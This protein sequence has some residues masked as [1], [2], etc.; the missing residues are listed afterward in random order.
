[1]SRFRPARLSVLFPLVLVTACGFQNLVMPHQG[2]VEIVV[3]WPNKTKA[4]RYGLLTIPEG[5]TRIEVTIL[6]EG[7]PG[8]APLHATLLPNPQDNSLNFLE[9]PVGIKSVEALAFDD[10]GREVAY[11]QV[12]VPVLPNQLNEATVEMVPETQPGSQPSPSP[13]VS[14]QPTSTPGIPSPTPPPAPTIITVAGGVEAAVVDDKDPTLARFHYPRAIAMDRGSRLLYVADNDNHLIRTYDL[15]THAVTTVAH[16]GGQSADPGTTT[17]GAANGLAVGPEGAVYFADA[18]NNQI[19]KLN[20]DGT[21]SVVAGSGKAGA[22]DGPGNIA[23]FNGPV[24]LAFGVD[25]YLYVADQL[26]GKI[27]RINLRDPDLT[28]TTFA[29]TGGNGFHGDNG[30]ALQATLDLP[31]AVAI[32]P[33]GTVLYEAE[34]GNRR[35]RKIQLGTGIIQTVAGNGAISTIGEGGPATTASL[36]L[37][38]SLAFD[39]LGNLYIADGWGAHVGSSSLLGVASRVLRVGNDG[40]LVRVA[41]SLKTDAAYGGDGGDP[42]LAQM[43]NPSGIAF[44]ASGDLFIADT[45]NNRLRAVMQVPLPASPTPVPTPTATGTPAP[46]PTPS[47]APSA[48]AVGSASGTAP[49]ALKGN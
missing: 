37:P 41:G 25:G 49:A 35:V 34:A 33:S 43:S 4:G 9:V 47:A 36:S 23:S 11:G 19:R 45:Y 3:N 38:M 17:L 1:M 29:G 39:N 46:S 24:S 27:R 28:V 22:D 32:A 18:E 31:T 7:I 16:L 2:K 48:Q 40:L 42:T 20:P 26:N 30:Q 6:G 12:T 14:T 13:T 5:T 8:D 15:V 10:Q 21:V 44:D